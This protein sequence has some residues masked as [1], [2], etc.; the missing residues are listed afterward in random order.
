MILD[1]LVVTMIKHH[2]KNLTLVIES[3]ERCF[4]IIEID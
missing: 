3:N 4:L 1:G 2:S